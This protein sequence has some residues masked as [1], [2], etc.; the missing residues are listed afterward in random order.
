MSNS[1]I[2]FVSLSSSIFLIVAMFFAINASLI[3]INPNY[4]FPLSGSGFNDSTSIGSNNLI[5]PIEFQKFSIRQVSFD[6]IGPNR[7]DTRDFEM[8]V[9]L[10]KSVLNNFGFS[11]E[12]QIILRGEK[13]RPSRYGKRP[14][15][16]IGTDGR[17]F[18]AY[19]F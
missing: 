15:F 8:F 13:P 10:D 18:K 7:C 12:S 17:I 5:S 1:A 19:C 4:H 11:A 9:G 6:D 16:E 2:K 3:A 14:V